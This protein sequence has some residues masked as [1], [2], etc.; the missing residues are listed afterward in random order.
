MH[1]QDGTFT[2][3]IPIYPGVDLIDVTGAYDLFSRIPSPWN[4]REYRTLVIA[5]TDKTVMSGQGLGIQPHATFSDC[6]DLSL[7]W[8][9]GAEKP[10]VN[11]RYRDFL[12]ERAKTAE[13]VTSVCT[14]ALIL[15][16]YGLLDGYEATTHWL[17]LDTLRKNAKVK[18]AAGYPRF[19]IDRNRITG[20]G[21]TSTLDEAL[22]VIALIT[23]LDVANTIQETVQYR[24]PTEYRMAGFPPFSG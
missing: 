17:A 12:V 24:F 7:L 4:G 9:P 10:T 21:V 14:G 3:G 19:V 22:A 23:R 16:E 15:A 1:K 13:W 6:G 18:V 20:G 8:V 5:E 2:I 11:D